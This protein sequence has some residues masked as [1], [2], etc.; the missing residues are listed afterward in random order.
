MARSCARPEAANHHQFEGEG[1]IFCLTQAAISQYAH[2]GDGKQQVADQRA[3]VQRPV[4][5]IEALTHDLTLLLRRCGR[6]RGDGHA[7]SEAVEAADN[8]HFAFVQAA[9]NRRAIFPELG[10]LYGARHCLAILHQP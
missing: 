3:V 8:D 2:Q 5:K 4:R 7:G 6:A 10:N 1:R 9:G